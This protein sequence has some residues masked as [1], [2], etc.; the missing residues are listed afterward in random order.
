MGQLFLLRCALGRITFIVLTAVTACA[1]C[2]LWANKS[3]YEH[4][5]Q[6]YDPRNHEYVIG[7]SDMLAINVWKDEELSTETRVRPDGTITMP[8]VGDLQ[9]AGR[10]PKQLQKEITDNVSKFVK[11]AI[12]TVAVTEVNSY[13]FMVTGEVEHPGVFTS[14][15][16]VTVSEAITRAGGPNR[17]AVEDEVVLI[18]RDPDGT[19]RRIPIDYESILKGTAPEQ[20]LVVLAGDTI[21]VP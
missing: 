19:V 3:R 14:R 18:R 12:V 2:N 15:Y 11:N 20:N 1:S 13:R 5:D 4:Y 7:I 9:A 10:T 16:Y 21:F 6:E 8:L 17:Y